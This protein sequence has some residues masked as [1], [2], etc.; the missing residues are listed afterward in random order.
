M[1]RCKFNLRNM[2]RMK[3]SQNL[4]YSNTEITK[5][6][7]LISIKRSSSNIEESKESKHIIFN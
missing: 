5:V 4:G 6:P 7:A 3:T 2:Y 1:I